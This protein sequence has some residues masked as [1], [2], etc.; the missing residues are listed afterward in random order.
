MRTTEVLVIGAGPGG[1]VCAIKLG[2]LGK[3]TLLVDKDKLGGECLNYGCIPSKALISSADL[4]HRSRKAAQAGLL[5]SGVEPDWAKV[6]QW[7]SAMV[8]GL[9]RGVGG[10]LKGNGVETLTGEARFTVPKEAVVQSPQGPET[11]SFTHAVIATGSRSVAL[12]AFPFDGKR[13]IGSREALDLPAAP[14]R[15]AVI[16]GGVIGLEIGTFFAKLGSKVTVIELMEQL[17]PGVEADLT[18]PVA[19]SLQKLGVTTHLRSKALGFAEKDGSLELTV[20]T[21]EGEK[22]VAS[23]LILQSVGRKPGTEGLGLPEAG[24][25]VDS[26]GFIQVDERFATSA[27]GIYAIGD[28]T[29]V[30]FLAHKASREGILAALSIAGREAE[31]RGVVPWAIFTDPEIAFAGETEAEAKARGVEVLVGKFPFSASGRAL[32]M[33]ETDGFVKVIGRKGDGLLLGA[34]IVGPDASDLI[35][36]ASL[37]LRMKATLAD[38]ANT[39]HPHPTLSEALQEAAEAALG[40]AIH[41]LSPAKK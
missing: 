23:D 13:V 28:A 2:K 25:K 7:K 35:G 31:P 26:R 8:G 37:A 22:S 40:E 12:P 41:I 3:K 9:G 33:R 29:G 36:E 5:P 14:A 11:V 38:L 27:P 15:L 4:A 19:R 1:Y 20:S 30:P 16:G 10:L 24:V 32:S 18:A 21:P 17:L 6:Q 34:G 39:V